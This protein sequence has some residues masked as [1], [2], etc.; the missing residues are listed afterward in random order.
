M[1][2]DDLRAILDSAKSPGGKALDAANAY[3]NIKEFI[4]EVG[5]AAEHN[6]QWGHEFCLLVML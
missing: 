3:D 5:L 4:Y 2:A 6:P 1:R